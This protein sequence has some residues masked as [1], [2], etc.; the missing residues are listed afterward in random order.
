MRANN[1]SCT[2]DLE[3]TIE[4]DFKTK[5]WVENLDPIKRAKNQKIWAVLRCWTKNS[6]ESDKRLEDWQLE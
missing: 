1:Y 5:E 2:V 3:L 4:M 6:E